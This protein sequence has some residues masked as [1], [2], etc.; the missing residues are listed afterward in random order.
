MPYLADNDLIVLLAEQ[1]NALIP[2]GESTAIVTA[3]LASVLG[4][5][6]DVAIEDGAAPP[7]FIVLRELLMRA[8]CDIVSARA[9]LT[10]QRES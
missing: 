6:I 2:D 9:N 8:C 3:A 5:V 10:P 1:I 7:D 4:A